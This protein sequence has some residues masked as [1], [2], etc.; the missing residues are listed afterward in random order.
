MRKFLQNE[1]G[2]AKMIGAIVALLV[3][4]AVGM[5]IFWEVS[6]SIDSDDIN[7]AAEEAWN[8]TNDT[9]TTV[10]SLAPIIGIVLIA[11]VILGVVSRFG[12]GGGF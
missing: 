4:I 1:D 8:D 6:D 7:G 10:F 9:A 3:I 5:M 2:Y 11:S 12:G